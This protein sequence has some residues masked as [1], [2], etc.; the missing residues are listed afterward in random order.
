MSYSNINILAMKKILL[1]I[2]AVTM[3][4]ACG[5]KSQEGDASA[6]ETVISAE[7]LIEITF[8]VEGMTCD[9]C[10]N[11]IMKS[12]E[13]LEGIA[14]VS[15]SH[16]EGWTKVSYDKTGPSAEDIQAKITDAGYTV[17]GVKE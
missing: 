9:G 1:L 6:E 3:S 7:N 13:Q 17:A 12:V 5:T 4:V 2:I 15:S 14:E 8:N 16:E 10:E 11:A